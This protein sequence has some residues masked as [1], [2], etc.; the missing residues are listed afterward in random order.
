MN[1]DTVHS[2]ETI[3]DPLHPGMHK[4]V[5]DGVTQPESLTIMEA[6]QKTDELL[7]NG[8]KTADELFAELGYEKQI[9]TSTVI[10]YAMKDGY[11]LLSINK[12][13]KIVSVSMKG[14]NY[15]LCFE[16]IKACAQ[17]IKEMEEGK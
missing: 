14:Q 15:G 12:E 9:E 7:R 1:Y 4:L 6:A 17:L 8:E 13:L 11:T 10:E 3:D 5:V 2:V 16:E